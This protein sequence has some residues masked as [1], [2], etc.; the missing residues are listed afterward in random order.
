MLPRH[1]EQRS[2]MNPNALPTTTSQGFATPVQ[3]TLSPVGN[4]R[5]HVFT[6]HPRLAADPVLARGKNR[7]TSTSGGTLAGQQA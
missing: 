2:H 6:D 3:I 4:V 5:D 7:R 1:D